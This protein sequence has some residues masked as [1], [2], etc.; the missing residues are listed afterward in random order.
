MEPS[1]ISQAL[2]ETPLFRDM[3]PEQV[4]VLL[5]GAEE[6]Q[7]ADGETIFR[8]GD[9]AHDLMFLVSGEVEIRK[10]L[11]EGSD[12]RLATLRAPTAFGEIAFLVSGRRGGRAIAKGDVTLLRLTR[13]EF[14]KI[15]R[16]E[17]PIAAAFLLNLSRLLASRLV[18]TVDSL[19]YF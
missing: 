7:Y 15:Y 16:T 18:E 14:D 4:D 2:A 6:A 12:S 1:P 10:R 8:E 9:D 3:T 19:M 13:Y 5:Q 17:T 11:V